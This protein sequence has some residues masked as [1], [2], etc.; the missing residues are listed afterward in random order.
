MAWSGESV[1]IEETM[2]AL[3]LVAFGS[4]VIGGG[5]MHCLAWQILFAVQA[6]AQFPQWFLSVW[7]FTSHRSVEF[8]LQFAVS[9]AQL[10]QFPVALLQ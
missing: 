6:V 3:L 5:E 7:R 10:V 9:G 4:R 2:N 1:V 8:K